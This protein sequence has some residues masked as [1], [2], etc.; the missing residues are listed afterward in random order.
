MPW[1]GWIILGVVLFGSELL[2]IDAAFYLIFIG[3]AAVITGLIVLIDPTISISIQWFAFAILALVAMVLFRKQ[4]Y[5]KLRGNLP[6]YKQGLDGEVIQ[7]PEPLE[8][9]GSCRLDYRGTT[10]TVK[11][12]GSDTI[13]D[14]TNVA[15]DKVEGLTIILTGVDTKR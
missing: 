5:A 1:W 12:H 10:W 13:P 14:K 9:G 7:L 8:P 4:L 2:L 3:T 11:N 15:I 6:G